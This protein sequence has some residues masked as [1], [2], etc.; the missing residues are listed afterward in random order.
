MK[1]IKA[2]LEK[3]DNLI[4]QMKA[5]V[6]SA[7]E[8]TRAFTDEEQANYDKYKAELANLDKTIATAEEFRSTFKKTEVKEKTA[9]EKQEDKNEAETR[10]FEKFIRGELTAE[11]R[12]AD[13]NL[14]F[15]DNGAVIPQSIA[16]KIIDKVVEISPIYQLATRYNVK[17]TLTIPY[18][19]ST[20]GDITM[21]YATEFT[22]LTSTSGNFKSISLSG[23]LAGVLTL[24]SKSLINNSNFDIVGFVIDKMAQS[25]A[26]WLEK[27]LIDGTK[28]KIEGLSTL[29]TAVTAASATAVTADELIDL[30]ES[31]PDIYQNG[32]IFIM[33]KA[34]RTAIRKLKDK[35]G[36]YLLNRDVSARWGYTLLGKDVYISDNMPVMAAGAK[37]IYYG[38]FSGLAVKISEDASIDILREKYATQ[39]ALGIYAYIE[40]DSKVE[41]AEKLAVLVN[42]GE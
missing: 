27:E 1:N 12:A 11:T 26:K 21:S 34:T 14:T 13:T 2:L 3:R 17:G 39:H 15:T 6:D 19:D 40:I 38:D 20:T 24:V 31:I 37:S 33:N 16:N 42:K 25:I 9:E 18:Y 5:I 23:F 41:N 8:E 30:Q 4:A 7:D 28:N 36:N 35:D 29:E 32:A 10:A 22:E